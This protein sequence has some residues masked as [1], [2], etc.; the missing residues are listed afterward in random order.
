MTTVCPG[1][2]IGPTLI[3]GDF[4]SGK[5]AGLFM[6]DN[7]PGGIPQIA[8]ATVDVREVAEAHVQCIKRDEA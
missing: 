8:F 5:V 7:L 3:P 1:F 6:N 4:S 2:V